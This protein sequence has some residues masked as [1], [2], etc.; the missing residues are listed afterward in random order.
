MAKAAESILKQVPQAKGKL[1]QMVLDLGSLKSVKAFAADYK[2]KNLPIHLLILNAGVM[3]CPFSKTEDG[4]EMQMGTN[5]C[6]Y[7]ECKI[8]I[9]S[10]LVILH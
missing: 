6:L 10:I 9:F 4:F 7:R 5:V 2:Q 3:A 1:E 8:M